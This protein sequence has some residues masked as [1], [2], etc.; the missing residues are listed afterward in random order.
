MEKVS[1]AQEKQVSSLNDKAAEI[2]PMSLNKHDLVRLDRIQ[3]CYRR[4]YNI[5]P[6]RTTVIRHAILELSNYVD[7][8]MIKL[9]D[10]PESPTSFPPQF[11]D[12]MQDVIIEDIESRVGELRD[13]LDRN[14]DGNFDE[15]LYDAVHDW[16][17]KRMGGSQMCMTKVNAC[18]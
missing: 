14:F 9:S 1:N 2:Y 15:I 13:T 11:E 16:L 10:A 3:N 17:E 12:V 5:N 7:G 18:I 8:E 6:S 4:F